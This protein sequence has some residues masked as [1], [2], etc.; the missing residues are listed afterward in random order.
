MRPNCQQIIKNAET[1]VEY[2]IDFLEELSAEIETRKLWRAWS[3]V[4]EHYTKAFSAMRRATDIG[5][6]KLWSDNL[7][8]LQKNDP[9]LQYAFQARDH[10]THIFEDTRETRPHSIS[11]ANLISV[12][13]SGNVVFENNKILGRDG[14]THNLPEGEFQ[15]KDG[16]FVGGTFPRGALTEKPH[17]I[18]LTD[19]K[20]RAGVFVI[21]NSSTPQDQQAIEIAKYVGS[22]LQSRLLEL[23]EMQAEEARRN[24]SDA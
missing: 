15:V 4:L 18:V 10:A 2:V 19:V 1:E 16:R 8:H 14:I 20:T 24:Q 11:L 5:S 17:H 13:G 9:I 6:S 3:G 22:W 21:P 7:K 23:K 12:S